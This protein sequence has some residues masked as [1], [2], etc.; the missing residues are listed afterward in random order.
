MRRIEVTFDSQGNSS[1]EAFGFTGSACLSA[2][3]S[4]EEAI[5]KI[6]HRAEKHGGGDDVKSKAVVSA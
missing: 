5:G 2:T 1:I 4:I 6:E 3:K